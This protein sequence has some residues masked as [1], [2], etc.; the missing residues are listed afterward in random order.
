MRRRDFIGVT[1]GSQRLYGRSRARAQQSA[2]PV[3]GLFE[4]ALTISSSQ[5]FVGLSQRTE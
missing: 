5:D 4:R 2:V 1:W 3:I